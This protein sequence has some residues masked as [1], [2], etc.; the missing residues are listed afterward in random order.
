MRSI[1]T[2]ADNPPAAA[3]ADRSGHNYIKAIPIKAIT[4]TA[5]DN[6]PA[7][8]TADTTGHDYIKAITM[9]AMTM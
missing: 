5:A 3:T 9:S 6:P 8:A 1:S 2:A 7:A 4:M